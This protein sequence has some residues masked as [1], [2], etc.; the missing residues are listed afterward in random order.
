MWK[1]GNENNEEQE[2]RFAISEEDGF[3]YKPAYNDVETNMR[4]VKLLEAV[5]SVAKTTNAR[6]C[7]LLLKDFSLLSHCRALK[8]YLMLGQGDTI[9]CL[10]DLLKKY[11]P[12]PASQIYRHHL[13]QQLETAV[14]AS[15]AQYEAEGILERLDVCI[16]EA[17]PGDSGWDVFTLNYHL[18]P[19]LN[20]V[21][22]SSSMEKYL[23][24]FTFLWKLKRVEYS[25]AETWKQHMIAEHSVRRLKTLRAILQKAHLV[26]NEM[27]HFASNLHN[28]MMFEVLETSWEQLVSNIEGADD[29]DEIV[30]AHSDY[31]ESIT[32]KS[33]LG[34]HKNG[35]SQGLL[36]EMLYSLF[37]I[38][39]KFCSVQERLYT[40]ILEHVHK[41][42]KMQRK[43]QERTEAGEWGIDET[44]DE[45]EK[46]EELKKEQTVIFSEFNGTISTNHN[47]FQELLVSF[48]QE[49]EKNTDLESLR[50][51]RFRLDFN[52]Y[53]LKNKS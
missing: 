42:G 40:K 52:H 12:K 41:L 24:I 37:D 53:F 13:N 34:V 9:Q 47:E 45:V 28:Y 29:L 39:I 17:S 51:L 50:F 23:E 49:L 43:I 3:C 16:M 14:R 7:K 20:S 8:Q 32:Q 4:A 15:N 30:K 19:P 2:N 31:L 46:E 36:K 5:D 25:L 1:A 21:V 18:T 27:I 48:I 26:R 6:L 35:A 44:M 38:I 33:L 22:T 10:M 11:L